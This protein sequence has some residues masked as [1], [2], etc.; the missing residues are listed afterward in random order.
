MGKDKEQIELKI[1]EF[2]KSIEPKRE[3]WN[4]LNEEFHN[5]HDR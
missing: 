2:R 4:N 3:A 5:R 1:A